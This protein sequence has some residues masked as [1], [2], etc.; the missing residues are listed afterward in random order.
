PPRQLSLAE[1]AAIARFRQEAEWQAQSVLIASS[2]PAWS[3]TISNRSD[4]LPTCLNR[5]LRL[6]EISDLAQ[7]QTVLPPQRRLLEACG[8]AAPA[9]RSGELEAMLAG[10][11]V[12]RVCALGEM[13]R[14]TLAWRQGGLSRLP[15]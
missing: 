15:V 6:V 5:C 11:G 13:Q 3:L 8:L 7:L 12:H 14:P 4:F 2:S 1:R 10:A 9:V